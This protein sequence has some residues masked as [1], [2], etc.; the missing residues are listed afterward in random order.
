MIGK[1]RPTMRASISPFISQRSLRTANSK[2]YKQV[3]L[4]NCLVIAESEA[5]LRVEKETRQQFDLYSHV[6][7]VLPDLGKRKKF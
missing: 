1:L 6:N 3:F 5:R 4:N 7:S 2:L